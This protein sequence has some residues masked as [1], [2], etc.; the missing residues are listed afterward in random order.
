M[1]VR[2][3]VGSTDIVTLVGVLNE[4]S[5]ATAW[6]LLYLW[7][8]FKDINSALLYSILLYSRPLLSSV[9]MF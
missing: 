9:Q 7:V 8:Q 5:S 1:L 2:S 6:S 4:D 3:R